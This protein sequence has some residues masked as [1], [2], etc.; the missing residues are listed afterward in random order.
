MKLWA[1]LL[2]GGWMLGTEVDES[3]QVMAGVESLTEE[4]FSQHL[5]VSGKEG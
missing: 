4:E 2:F 3:H 5:K 1:I